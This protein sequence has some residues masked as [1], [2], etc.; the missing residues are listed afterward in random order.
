MSITTCLLVLCGGE[1]Y[2]LPQ[3][4]I[5]ELAL[6]DP[7]LIQ[8]VE[9]HRLYN[10]RGRL[11]PM[12]SATSM[13]YP[14]LEGSKEQFIA[15]IKTERHLFGM[16]LDDILNPEEIVIR[17]L[18]AHLSGIPYFSGAAIMG[19]GEAVLILDATG[20][21]RANSLDAN[22]KEEKQTRQAGVLENQYLMFHS[23]GR[24]F[25]A[26]I[27]STPRIVL[28]QEAAIE[29]LVGRE[30]VQVKGSVIPVIRLENIIRIPV[31]KTDW[32]H[33]VIFEVD[34]KPG[35]VAAHEVHSVERLASIEHS[36]QAAG[37]AGHTIWNDQTTIVIDPVRLI[38]A[39][40][41]AH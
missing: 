3:Q 28:V 1:R 22:L 12:L 9:D 35:A 38:R 40:R 37:L 5:V 39:E 29:D 13:L 33:L 26:S 4:N 30:V 6:L 34:G 2:A 21:A 25:A 14:E 16:A 32:V 18:G 23:S 10:L 27:E 24:A 19:D 20:I 11:I 7:S 41:E 36:S 15:V 8:I 17:P 31:K